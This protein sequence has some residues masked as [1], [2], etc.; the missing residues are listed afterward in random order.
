[1]LEDMKHPYRRAF[2]IAAIEKFD[3]EQ[4]TLIKNVNKIYDNLYNHLM[5]LFDSLLTLVH[6]I[7]SKK[8]VKTMFP[9]WRKKIDKEQGK[10]VGRV[11]TLPNGKQI[12]IED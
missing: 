1:M 11:F 5:F 10:P 2:L 9:E 8:Q 7:A 6:N 12:E 3:S 4:L